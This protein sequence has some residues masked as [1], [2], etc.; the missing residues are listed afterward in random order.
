M[1]DPPCDHCDPSPDEELRIAR[2]AIASGDL[3]HAAHHVAGL[4]AHDPHA[5]PY[6][7][8]WGS[9]SAAAGPQLAALF[10]RGEGALWFGLAA[11]L[12]RAQYEQGNADA[13]YVQLCQ[14]AWAAPQISYLEWTRDWELPS[15]AA[16][17]SATAQLLH[18]QDAVLWQRAMASF[19]ER[20]AAA[21][22]S[23]AKLLTSLS[24]GARRSGDA[25]RAVALARQSLRA[26]PT[27]LGEIALANACRELG[28]VVEMEAAWTRAAEID[29]QD[30]CALLDWGDYLLTTGDLHAARDKYTRAL[31]RSP[32]D[33]WATGSIWYLD[34]LEAPSA[35]SRQ[36]LAARVRA[37]PE[38]VRARS[39]LDAV[40]PWLG[41]L[42]NPTDA[43]ANM[44]A[45][46]G[47]GPHGAF[48][49]A[50][51][52]LEG[53]SVLHAAHCML[54]ELTL[55]AGRVPTPDPRTPLGSPRWR[56]YEWTDLRPL[57]SL[58]RPH[59]EASA[60]LEPLLEAAY[61]ADAWSR[62]ASD[63]AARI[64]PAHTS[65]LLALAVH[66]QPGPDPLYLRLWTQQHAV[67][68][69]LTAML[70]LDSCRDGAP[71]HGLRS[72][73]A[74]RNDWAAI[75]A[76]AAL[77]AFGETD[78]AVRELALEAALDVL[79]E[80]P[81]EGSW[82]TAEPAWYAVLRLDPDDS[83]GLHDRALQWLDGDD[84]S[85]GST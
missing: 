15:E 74:V 84:V 16:L 27:W 59:Q 22:P 77:T 85:G 69:V 30:H 53:A 3:P 39:A 6:L 37:H 19:G 41:F 80:A 18:V 11:C 14:V 49:I 63:V 34:Y 64:E 75:A 76:L 82:E 38:N 52:H 42:P 79:R 1:T 23:C 40:T 35:R 36:R 13:A 33:A 12:A 9:L 8:L 58:P 70:Q 50:V 65:E 2:D 7:R 66:A 45:S 5:P 24:I 46:L 56:L 60:Y 57:P 47:D 20:A 44:L 72:M 55:T 29:P 26:A 71:L 78:A 61:G 62:H 73:L 67:A 28:D 83:L 32:G 17:C 54:P 51:T 10:D 81:N 48:R 43:T 68:F 21:H 31:G 4:L 25:R